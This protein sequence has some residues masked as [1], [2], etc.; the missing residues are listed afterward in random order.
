MWSCSFHRQISRSSNCKSSPSWESCRGRHR[1]AWWKG[2]CSCWDPSACYTH[3][4]AGPSRTYSVGRLSEPH[5]WC[6]CICFEISTHCGALESTR[7]HSNSRHRR[8]TQ[9]G[10]RCR[11]RRGGSVGRP[12]ITSQCWSRNLP[13]AQSQV[14]HELQRAEIRRQG[15]I[16][17]YL[18]SNL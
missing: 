6:Y 10:H 15:E 14:R 4:S 9:W 18:N 3:R 7:C 5:S 8:R 16:T 13:I 17:A 12:P 2:P 11:L 1:I